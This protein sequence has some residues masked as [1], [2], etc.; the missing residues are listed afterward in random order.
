MMMRG[1]LPNRRTL[2][3]QTH[4]NTPCT[5]LPGAVVALGNALDG[6]PHGCHTT[7][8][9]AERGAERGNARPSLRVAAPP[10]YSDPIDV[11]HR[12]NVC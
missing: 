9:E 4:A 5:T 1:P 11:S 7:S 12:F 8:S 3:A 2:S 10:Q 6:R